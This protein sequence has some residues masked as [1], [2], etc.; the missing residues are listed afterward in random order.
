MKRA[1]QPSQNLT[2]NLKLILASC[3]S[4]PMFTIHFSTSSKINSLELMIAMFSVLLHYPSSQTSKTLICRTFVHQVVVR[5]SHMFR[6]RS[7]I[8]RSPVAIPL[9]ATVGPGLKAQEL[10]NE[11][12][13]LV[14]RCTHRTIYVALEVSEVCQVDN[15]Q[16]DLTTCNVTS[17]GMIDIMAVST[18]RIL[19]PHWTRNAS[20]SFA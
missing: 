12:S 20:E 7:N 14:G 1:L 2:L 17:A 8:S 6:S 9:L 3:Q 19:Y 18:Y 13:L 15:L 11:G 4:S 10:T 5:L 16:V